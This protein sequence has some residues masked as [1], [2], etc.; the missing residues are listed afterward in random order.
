MATVSETVAES[1][2][3]LRNIPWDLYE[4][5][6]RA[7]E[8]SSAPRFTYDHGDLEIMAPL[9]R[10]ERPNRDFEAIIALICMERGVDVE[11]L[12]STT[13]RRRTTERGA[14][15]DSCF[16]VRRT[17]RVR[18]KDRIDFSTDPP[19]DLVVEIEVTSPLVPKL[20]IWAEFG[21]PEVWSY[22]GE[23]VRI[24]SLEGGGYVELEESLCL[25]GVRSADLTRLL[26]ESWRTTRSEWLRR[27]QE[28]AR[29]TAA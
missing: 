24:L 12:G 22:D 16:Y 3:V 14:E 17:E 6:L 7:H 27:V 19:P 9:P 21:V 26:E 13:F 25:T 20:P 5:I 10:H 8:S 23:K 18:G 2:V 1:R 15:P 11:S 29:G 4:E 28:W